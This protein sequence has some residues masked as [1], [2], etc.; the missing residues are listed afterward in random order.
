MTKDELAARILD[1]IVRGLPAR[2]S[3]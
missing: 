3:R 1:Q 2:T